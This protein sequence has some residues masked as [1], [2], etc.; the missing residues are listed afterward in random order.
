MIS[1]DRIYINGA[2][3]RPH[4]TAVHAQ[5]NPATKAVI[6]NTV[7][8][9]AEDVARAVAAARAAFP[10]F[11]RT[12]VA[13]RQALLHRLHDAVQAREDAL[14]KATLQEYGGP[15][16]DTIARTRFAARAFLLASETLE[17]FAFVRRIGKATILMEPLGV[18]GII[19]PWNA[20]YTLL[21]NKLASAIAAGCTAV[22]KPSELS[23]LQTDALLECI[24]AAGL[25]AGVVNVVNGTG[26]EVGTAITR[27]PDIAL[28]SFTG[29]T[30]VGRLILQGAAETLKRVTLELGGKSANIILDDADLDKAI[31][32]AV[33][34]AFANSG[35][36]CVAG[37]RLL[38]PADMLPEIRRRLAQAVAAVQVGDPWDEA[39]TIGPIVSQTQY[40]RVQRYIHLGIDE[41]ATLLIG[42]PG[43]PEGLEHGYFVRPTV[44]E[45]VTP[46]MTI[47]QEEIF[48]PVLCLMSYETEEQAIEIANGTMYGL[49]AYVSGTDLARARRVAARLVAG[50]VLINRAESNEPKAPFGGFK[51]SGIGREYGP[52]GLEGH[53]EP[54]ALMDDEDEL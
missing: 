41:G 51:Q 7:L 14:V 45:H 49:A 43:H 4:G 6:G 2:F 17:T 46:D 20:N 42:G 47:A 48:G 19:T 54:K 27:H 37:T 44:F 1:I 31:P 23:T 13:E 12:S 52:F 32:L 33:R 9:D 34:I 10:A 24:H 22:V 39:T 8:G 38:V 16:K 21:C 40:E 50:R 26:D 28:I 5:I 29:S 53:L 18:V 35:Q 3:V 11:S 25:P 30:R 36:A 15:L